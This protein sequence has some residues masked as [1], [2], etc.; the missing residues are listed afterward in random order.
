M[1]YSTVRLKKIVV[2]MVA[3][4][5]V[6]HKKLHPSM[7]IARECQSLSKTNERNLK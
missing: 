5:E 6:R 1:I 7:Q 3:P 2:R 4:M